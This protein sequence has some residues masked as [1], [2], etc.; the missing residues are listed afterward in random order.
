MLG[1]FCKIGKGEC[2]A[3]GSDSA[4]RVSPPPSLTKERREKNKFFRFYGALAYSVTKQ[5]L[6]GPV[7]G[8]LHGGSAAAL[9]LLV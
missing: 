4:Q 5:E 9:G 7:L 3:F 1:W 2:M 8:K 6:A